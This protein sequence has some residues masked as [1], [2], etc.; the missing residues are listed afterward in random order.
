MVRRT[1]PAVVVVLFEMMTWEKRCVGWL[2]GVLTG[3][4]VTEPPA[5]TIG[6]V[7]VAGFLVVVLLLLV[8]L[9]LSDVIRAGRTV[10]NV[11]L[12]LLSLLLLLLV[13]C[14]NTAVLLGMCGGGRYEPFCGSF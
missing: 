14:V 1:V 10:V 3:L 11:P 4:T 7:L 13:V 8:L 12:S 6:V 2:V 9:L 5:A